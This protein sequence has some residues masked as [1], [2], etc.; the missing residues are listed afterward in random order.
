MPKLSVIILSY[1]TKEITKKTL[2]HLIKSLDFSKDISFEIIVVDNASSDGSVD[3]ISDLQKSNLPKNIS[4]KTIFNQEN[5][6]F[7]KGNNAALINAEGEYILFLNSDVLVENIKWQDIFD[8]MDKNKDVAALTIKLKLPSGKIDPA[9]HRGFPTV[10]NSLC[11]FSKLELITKKIPY[12]N[13]IFG[14]YHMTYKNIHETHSV[15]AIS[16]AFFLA[17][18]EIVKKMEG[19]DEDFFMYGE[20]I[21][22]AYRI[23]KSGYKIIYFPKY[24]ALH[25]KYQSGIGASGKNTKSQTKEYFYNA[26][27]IFYKKHYDK[28]NNILLNKI[29]Y[30]AIDLKSRL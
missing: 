5:E 28:E 15:D 7:P 13:K 2:N 29:I 12:L 3:A 9:S 11:Y 10:W 6:G 4:F 22:L 14:G 23:K 1:N 24:E 17:R 30:F 18:S 20:D 21:D 27:R 16:G 25:L 19:F 8:Y 26:M